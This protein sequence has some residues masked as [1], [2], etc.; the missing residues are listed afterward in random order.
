[1]RAGRK[2]LN[3]EVRS[4]G[5]AVLMCFSKASEAGVEVEVTVK[6]NYRQIHFS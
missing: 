5:K 1:M 6:L 3:F 2:A 4:G